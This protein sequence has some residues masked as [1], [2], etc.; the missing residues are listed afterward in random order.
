L[1]TPLDLL[2]PVYGWFTEGL[3]TQDLKEAKA[4]LHELR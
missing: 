3:D 4:L 2:A 1:T